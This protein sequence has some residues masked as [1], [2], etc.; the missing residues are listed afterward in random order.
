[1]KEL[2]ATPKLL[3]TSSRL[4]RAG[5]ARSCVSNSLAVWRSQTA[6]VTC[7]EFDGRPRAPNAP[8]L[9]QHSNRMS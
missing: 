4:R 5:P 8:K 9:V 1:M 6:T 2:R 3:G 7:T